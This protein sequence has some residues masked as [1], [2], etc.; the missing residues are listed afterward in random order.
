MSS[1]LDAFDDM[2]ADIDNVFE[3]STDTNDATLGRTIGGTLGSSSER[4]SVAVVA[5]PKESVPASAATTLQRRGNRNSEFDEYNTIDGIDAALSVDPD[6]A[7]AAQLDALLAE[8][9][10]PSDSPKKFTPNKSRND[11]DDDLEAEYAPFPSGL[12]KRDPAAA[13]S[14]A[15]K[16]KAAMPIARAQIDSAR[17]LDSLLDS[18]DADAELEDLNADDLALPSFES[19]RPTVP[20]PSRAV[21]ASAVPALSPA[22]PTSNDA[23]SMLDDMLADI[24]SGGAASPASMPY[25]FQA[26]AKALPSIA[27]VVSAPIILTVNIEHINTTKKMK[28]QTDMTVATVIA[29]VKQQLVKMAQI[30]G[31]EEFVLLFNSAASAPLAADLVIGTL[32]PKS[33]DNVHLRLAGGGASKPPPSSAAPKPSPVSAPLPNTA[34]ML[35][36]ALPDVVVGGGGGGGHDESAS[37]PASASELPSVP[38]GLTSLVLT[39][40]V[41]L[42]KTVKKIKFSGTDTVGDACGMV[43]AVLLKS[44]LLQEKAKNTP[45][46]FYRKE[47]GT[48]KIEKS[49]LLRASELKSH[50]TVFMLDMRDPE[51]KLTK[52]DR[53]MLAA[54]EDE[55][56]TARRRVDVL[57]PR[58]T[59][60]YYKSAAQSAAGLLHGAQLVGYM[61]KEGSGVKSWRRRLFV[62]HGQALYYFVTD[63]DLE[64]KGRLDLTP[65]TTVR[66]EDGKKQRNCFSVTIAKRTLYVYT[67]EDYERDEWK[68][69]ILQAGQ[70]GTV[71]ASVQYEATHTLLTTL[72]L[73]ESRDSL[74]DALKRVVAIVAD[75]YAHDVIDHPEDAAWGFFDIG[76]APLTDAAV[77]DLDPCLQVKPLEPTK[78]SSANKAPSTFSRLLSRGQ[79]L[80]S[81]VGGGATGAAAKPAKSGGSSVGGSSAGGSAAA[82]PKHLT[83]A[84]GEY[85]GKVVIAEAVKNEDVKLVDT[86][87]ARSKPKM[88]AGRKAPT[89]RKKVEI[90]LDRSE[91]APDLDF[92]LTGGDDDAPP[93]S[94]SPAPRGSNHVPAGAV[95]LLSPRAL[96]GGPSGRGAGGTLARGGAARGGGIGSVMAGGGTLAR[97][98]GGAAGGTLARG[99]AS[100]RG[101]GAGRGGG[102][103]SPSTSSDDVF[104]AALDLP[105]VV[106]ERPKSTPVD[107]PPAAKSM[108]GTLARGGGS[109]VV[110]G[111]AAGRGRGAPGGIGGASDDVFGAASALPDVV[112]E[113]P[114]STPPVADDDDDD[115]RAPVPAKPTAPV[116][117]TGERRSLPAPSR[118]ASARGAS[119]AARG[120]APATLTRGGASARGAAAAP[121]RGRALPTPAGRAGGG[122]A[123][124]SRG[125]RAL[126][127]PKP[128]GE[129][130]APTAAAAS[131]GDE[132]E[133]LTDNFD[134]MLEGLD[135]GEFDL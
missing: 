135:G 82:T 71:S 76:E 18:V 91:I 2:L 77:A 57:L 51:Q 107:E 45:F 26:P 36:M 104:G 93:V 13:P 75:D 97:G 49:T 53:T 114:K 95:P 126:P 47:N 15:F 131:I 62:L 67:D 24:E 55:D 23:E 90:A 88:A 21:G 11:D 38:A 87:V 94:A 61:T 42:A 8:T 68:A 40:N 63:E 101:R 69:A 81:S 117:N 98:G 16:A 112:L 70:N 35:A 132:L 59:L 34:S 20:K 65:L 108:G 28:F 50:D 116:A 78:I 121:T 31:A 110:R 134:D 44:H 25:S 66:N 58:Q 43:A 46:C 80:L 19:T 89:R 64:P 29:T 12:K 54:R 92:D 14:T 100:G 32:Q 30:Q 10:V 129:A 105:D 6:A 111:G 85:K 130:A 99:G 109:A 56:G 48:G 3:N 74:G 60:E 72:W 115:A 124:P 103:G 52:F 17:E 84:T 133:D 86:S 119:V 73:S 39:V 106:L 125:G 7:A 22:K 102:G 1:T 9:G 79:D 83:Q 120:A 4:Y 128:K 96:E 113:R 122:G 127:T 123:A 41:P 118:A 27:A 37:A 33:M 5:A